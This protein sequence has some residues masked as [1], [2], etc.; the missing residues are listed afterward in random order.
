MKY[1]I[2]RSKK[3]RKKAIFALLLIVLI[4]AALFLIVSYSTDIFTDPDSMSRFLERIGP[5]SP[6]IF[7]FL[8]LLQILFAPFPGQVTGLASG[9]LYGS[10][11]GTTYTMIGTFLG[12]I[13]AFWLSRR[14]GRPFVER[15][16]EENT[17]ERFDYIT[18]EKALFPLFL[19]FLLPVFPDD[20]ICFIAG[21][22]KI[23]IWQLVI[24]A[25]IG[26]F[27][28]MLVL[29]LAGAGIAGT[30][31]TL[32]VVVFGIGL[33]I[34]I[35]IFIFGKRLRGFFDRLAGRNDRS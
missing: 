27:P 19:I 18:E 3:A 8:Q 2:F 14:Y 17:L 12:T 10:L 6:I 13:I 31:S 5:Y 32:A 11:L 26:R 35:P 24:I 4:F 28:G 20:A 34:S 30:D 23:P 16:V 7:I 25:V 33:L 9:Y 29:N 21:L 22:T 1:R 15:V